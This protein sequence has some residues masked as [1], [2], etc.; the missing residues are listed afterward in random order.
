MEHKVYRAIVAAVKS[1]KLVEPFGR[2]EFRK[3][4]P[5]FGEG[6]YQAFL[7]KHAKGNGTDTELLV[8]VSRGRYRLIRPFLYGEDS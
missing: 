6:T 8:R 4:C 1:G 7:S 3:A 5:K 2:A